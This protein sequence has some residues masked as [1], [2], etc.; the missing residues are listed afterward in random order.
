MRTEWK[1]GDVAAIYAEVPSGR[2]DVEVTGRA[3]RDDQG[4]WVT[5]VGYVVADYHVLTARRLVV[6]DPEDAGQVQILSDLRADADDSGRNTKHWQD[7]QEA[8]RKFANPKPAACRASLNVRLSDRAIETSCNEP[9]GHDGSHCSANGTS[10][11]ASE[12]P[13]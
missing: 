7:M 1:Q 6:I 9:V 13:K 12:V 5:E 2:S 8:L 3:L 4:N 10:W 11:D